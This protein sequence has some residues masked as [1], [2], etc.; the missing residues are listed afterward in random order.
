ARDQSAGLEREVLP[1]QER[2]AG[3]A[4]QAY[5]EGARDLA[6]AQQAQ[7]DL[8]AVRF[9]IAAARI[10]AAQRWVE[11]QVAAGQEPGAR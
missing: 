1:V 7:R 10:A 8:S 6:T 11:L 2:A 3:L 5:R 4:A 9:E